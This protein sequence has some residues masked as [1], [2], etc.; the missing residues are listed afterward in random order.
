MAYR[1][2]TN[3]ASL[4][5]CGYKY[6]LSGGHNIVVDADSYLLGRRIVA[7]DGTI[8]D[9]N[10]TGSGQ[11]T[12]D[13]MD[14]E[15]SATGIRLGWGCGCYTDASFSATGTGTFTLSATGDTSATTAM[16][17]GM[18]GATSFNIIANW[19]SSFSVADYSVTAD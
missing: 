16:A 10:A 18:V 6:Q 5:D 14:S 19:L 11:A 15:A 7:S 8:S 17:P 2:G 13:C 12:L 1:T 9:L 3:Y 4:K